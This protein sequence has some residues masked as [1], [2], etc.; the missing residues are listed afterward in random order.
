MHNLEKATFNFQIKEIG[1]DDSNNYTFEGYAS[2]YG[3]V[4]YG[5]D[6]IDDGAFSEYM[7]S[8]KTGSLPVLWQHDHKTPIGVFQE[9]RSDSTGLFVKGK[10]PKD[11][12]FVRNRVVPQLKIGS[13]NSMSIGFLAKDVEYKQ[14]IRHITDAHLFEIS[15]VSIPMNPKAKLTSFK[16]FDC[17]SVFKNYPI[18]PLNTAWDE[19]EAVKRVSD[20]LEK[21]ETNEIKNSHFWFSS[22]KDNLPFLDVIEGKLMAVPRA[23]FA[24]AANVSSNVK[25]QDVPDT[26]RKKVVD[27]IEKYYER[28]SRESPFEKGLGISELQQMEISYIEKI[29]Q[30]AGLNRKTARHMVTLYIKNCKEHIADSEIDIEPEIKSIIEKLRSL[31]SK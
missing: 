31:K 17:L 3:N 28:M 26:I 20:F 12:E 10:L 11:D 24:A 23:I 8:F 29:F 21:D 19:K 6:V 30:K 4:D 7:A 22:D 1:E 16:N 9:M 15:L 25:L 27:H 2:T 14:S 13:V 18:A 5:N